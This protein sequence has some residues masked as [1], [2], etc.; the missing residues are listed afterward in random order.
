MKSI[1]VRVGALALVAVMAIFLWQ[2]HTLHQEQAFAIQAHEQNIIASMS[3]PKQVRGQQHK[4]QEHGQEFT[5]GTLEMSRLETFQRCFTDPVR[6]HHHFN[7]RPEQI[8]CSAS[9]TFNLMYYL[10]EKA[11][12][13]TGR[14]VMKHLF[15][16]TEMYWCSERKKWD[17]FHFTEL[18]SNDTSKFHFTFFR[19]PTSRFVSSYQEVI[20][21]WFLSNKTMD[22]PNQYSQVFQP[23]KTLQRG[24]YNE[25]Y[26]ATEGQQVVIGALRQF[27]QAYDAKLPF[28]T[29]LRLQIPRL[30]NPATGRTMRL[31]GIYDTRDIEQAF[32]TLGN[33]VNATSDATVIHDRSS[34]RLDTS[35]L[36]I[37]EKCKICQLSAIDYCCLNYKLPAECKNSVTCRWIRTPSKQ[38]GPDEELLI[39]PVS[40]YPPLKD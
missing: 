30:T 12:S 29:H 38:L 4:L 31:D 40:L 28:E 5:P 9:E 7:L 33:M 22:I 11:G 14:Y 10:I 13:S 18:N 35:M 15:N 8:I 6:Y 39:E 32:H 26:T 17:Q 27:I 24:Q 23:F 34:P 16:A 37:S 25:L 3:Q 2:S 20:V 1:W 19:E 21:R 36:S